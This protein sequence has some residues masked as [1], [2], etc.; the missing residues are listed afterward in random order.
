MR[1]KI[2]LLL[3][4]VVLLSVVLSA[5]VAVPPAANP[6]VRTLNV[7]GTSQVYLTPDI[8]Y[9]NLGVHTQSEDA[10]QALADNT[11][12]AEALRSA[13]KELGI[14]DKDIQTSNFSVYPSQ[15]YDDNGKITGIIFMVDN[16]VYVTVR[17]LDKLGDILSAAVEAGANNINGIS[18][19]VAD[20]AAAIEQ[21][22]A[23]A[24]KNARQQAE[25][26]AKAAGVT[27]V[28][29]QNISYYNSYPTPLAMDVKAMG[30]SMMEYAASVPVA[31]G[32][33][34][35]TVDVSVVYEIK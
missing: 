6:Q 10:K 23:E 14:E 28:N 19:D 9:I 29:I 35:I 2:T 12:Q 31:T 4:A 24:V 33:M 13:L 3:S 7:N 17:K 5:C 8:A 26:L 15:Q 30:G 20:K 21:G 18:F 34:I 27:L 22:R 1:T 11:A 16:T 25:S 32:Q